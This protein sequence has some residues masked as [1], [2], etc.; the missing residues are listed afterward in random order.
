MSVLSNITKAAGWYRF[1]GKTFTI[2]VL[3]EAGSAVNVSTADLV[4]YVLREQGSSTKYLTKTNAMGGG[5]AVIG[6]DNNVVQIT[7]EVADYDDLPAGN[8]HHEL[9]DQGNDLLLSFGDAF[10]HDSQGATIV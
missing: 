5:I 7:I 2:T 1:E 4:W 3:N 8:H 10:L 9:W 6:T